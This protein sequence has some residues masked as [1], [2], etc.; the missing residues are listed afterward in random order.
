MSSSNLGRRKMNFP[1]ERYS[2]SR[3]PLGLPVYSG[4]GRGRGREGSERRVLSTWD[5]LKWK[6]SHDETNVAT[7]LSFSQETQRDVCLR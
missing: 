6:L 1:R 2:I 3:H 5:P 4:G 7:K